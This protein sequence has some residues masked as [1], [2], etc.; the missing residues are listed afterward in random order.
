VNRNVYYL[1]REDNRII[2][3]KTT[4]D[5]SSETK[6]LTNVAVPAG[7]SGEPIINTHLKLSLSR[8]GTKLLLGVIPASNSGSAVPELRVLDTN[9]DRFIFSK[10]ADF[11]RIRGG[12]F[13]P[14]NKALVLNIRE[15]GVS[16][17]WL[18]PLGEE[19]AEQ[20]TF[21]NS[22]QIFGG[23]FSPDA[24]HMVLVRGDQ[25]RDAVLIA[26]KTP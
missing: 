13:T 12:W 20:L 14:D 19:V 22:G 16:N 6:L 8:D 1:S 25:K 2:L 9:Q 10:S 15:R 3:K 7:S 4:L 23:D 5:G 11:E 21:F 24:K 18:Q 17:L 26:E